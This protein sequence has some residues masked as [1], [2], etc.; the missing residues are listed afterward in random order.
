[1]TAATLANLIIA[2]PVLAIAALAVWNAFDD[3][4]A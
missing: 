1:M 4:R 2:L 3:F